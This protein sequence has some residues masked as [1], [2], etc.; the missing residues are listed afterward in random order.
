ML[1]GFRWIDFKGLRHLLRLTLQDER[2]L[3]TDFLFLILQRVLCFSGY[4]DKIVWEPTN[5][6]GKLL[7]TSFNHLKLNLTLQITNTDLQFFKISLFFSGK[8]KA[9]TTPPP[10]TTSSPVAGSVRG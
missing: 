8:K 9:A 3:E 5:L 7:L 10:I 2:P 4:S 1:D 6:F